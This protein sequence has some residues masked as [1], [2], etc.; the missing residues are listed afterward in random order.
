MPKLNPKTRQNAKISQSTTNK[1][2]NS[3]SAA[4]SNIRNSRKVTYWAGLRVEGNLSPFGI[5]TDDL[6]RWNDKKN[7][8]GLFEKI[9][10]GLAK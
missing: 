5:A 7:N 1:G 6:T 3:R 8:G 9:G 4:A 2:N 10:Q